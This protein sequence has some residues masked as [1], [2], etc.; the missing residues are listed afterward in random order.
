MPKSLKLYVA[1]VVVIGAFALVTA[2]FLF[3]PKP[4]IAVD[5][6]MPGTDPFEI[7]LGIL[8]WTAITLLASAW[9]VQQPRGSQ[10][11]VA[12]APIM[13]SFMLG[14]PAVGGWVAAIGTTELREVRG[15]IPWYGTLMNHAAATL[16]A[17]LAGM[18]Y[19]WLMGLAQPAADLRLA[20]DF[21]AAVL[22]AA[23]LFTMNTVIVSVTVALRSGQ[24]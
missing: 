1:A 14:G 4:G 11:G 12:V 19:L 24:T 18:L 3:P 10:I 7:A 16:P 9:P 23:L 15:R 22:A 17:V 5:I 21:I 8:A 2:T 13:A 20:T 6:G